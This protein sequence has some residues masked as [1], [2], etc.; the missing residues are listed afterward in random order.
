MHHLLFLAFTLVAAVP[1]AILAIWEGHTAF[2]NELT[3]VRER[4]LLVARNLT[5]TLSRYANDVKSAF[6]LTLASGPITSPVPGLSDLLSSLNVIHVC[7]LNSDGSV[8]SVL[9]GLSG[10]GPMA[11]ISKERF[12]VLRGIVAEA[13]DQ[14]V[15]TKLYHDASGKPIFYLLKLLPGDKL[16]VGIVNTAYL[17]A[18]QQAIAFG[19]HGHAVITDAKGQVISHPLKDWV[20]ASR[21]I[22]GVS[23]VAAMM[24]GETGVGQFYSPAFND[25]MIAGY[26]V[27][28]ETGWG[29]MVPQPIGELKR[30]AEMVNQLALIV[31]IV[32]FSAAA[33]LSYF[34]AI[35]L[36]GPVRRVAS[37]A[38]AVVRGQEDVTAP[39][40]GRLAP[41]EIQG[42]GRA[43][44]TMLS[45]L[46]RRAADAKLAL[47][48][49]ETSNRAKTR[50]LANMSHEL[51]TPLNGV[52]GMLE[53][54]KLSG[55]SRAQTS[56]IEQA[57]E[58]ARTLLHVVND[59]LDLSEMEVGGIDLKQNPFRLDIV[60]DSI[61]EQFAQQAE[62]K[63]LNLAISLPAPLRVT[64]VG[65]ARRVSQM[66]GNLVDNAIKFT[67]SGGVAIRVSATEDQATSVR[68]R[69]EVGDTGA[70]IPPEDQ[71]KIF[72]AFSQ[73]DTSTTRRHGGGG[74]GLAI[75]KELTRRMNGTFGV[76]SIV[77]VG[78][79]FWISLP[80]QKSAAIPAGRP[81]APPVAVTP[82][83]PPAPVP[84]VTPTP[85]LLEDPP[86]PAEKPAE[87][88][89]FPPVTTAIGQRFR[90]TLRDMGRSS[91]K[92][93]LVEDNPANARVTKALLETLGC[94]VHNATNGVEAVAAYLRDTFDLVLMDC[95]M[96]EMDGYQA[97]RIIRQHER[98][99]DRVTPIIALTAH[100]MDGTREECLAAGMDDQLS[101]PLALAAL[102][103]KLAEW[104]AVPMRPVSG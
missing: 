70:G 54:L 21:D 58:S 10:N 104:L 85:V 13:A 91:A 34:F 74:L 68:I 8:D 9:P 76:Q 53:L 69:F 87:P 28:P 94:E 103:S 45:E 56:Y 50:F 30:R 23:V 25:M 38:E 17:V 5:T 15:L 97:T 2:Q 65:D 75:V 60:L 90:E 47:K 88:A 92:I 62:A 101:K 99:L 1:I 20:A 42:M 12:A 36:S 35:W 93:L 6:A 33:L 41:S 71:E 83:P 79:T 84:A 95:Q 96:P 82:T 49:I 59:V 51:R 57:N 32:A 67:T 66:I 102:T 98:Q 39:V 16:G 61:R 40:F 18:L 19:D 80:F 44:N 77:G 81:E 63:G 7:I 26:A 78:S 46:R 86:K 37:T 22:S 11:M 73:G 64:L 72:E 27:V 43:F 48:E 24:R 31:A 100:A 14:P 29:V 89:R 3:S 52:V 4:H 55:L